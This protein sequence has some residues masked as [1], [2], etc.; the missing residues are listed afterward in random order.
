MYLLFFIHLTLTVGCGVWRCR[1][2]LW[3]AHSV[4]L[5]AAPQSVSRRGEERTERRVAPWPWIWI[6]ICRSVAPRPAAT[7]RKTGAERSSM[8]LWELR[9]DRDPLP[10]NHRLFDLL[11]ESSSVSPTWR[12]QAAGCCWLHTWSS[13]TNKVRRAVIHVL[14]R[15]DTETVK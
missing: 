9:T 2:G 7:G 6:W 1:S 13:S 5:P 10:S 3:A 8:E 11:T 15:Y 12:P 4:S 14:S